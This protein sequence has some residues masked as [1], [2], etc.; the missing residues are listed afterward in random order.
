MTG[1]AIVSGPH[2]HSRLTVTN[3]MAMVMIC[4]LPATVMG[5]WQFGWPAIL[6]F[7][8]TV[9]SCLGFEAACLA[10]ARK[11]VERFLFD[12]SA[13]LTGW[14]LAM[15]LPP[16]APWWVGVA[17]AFIA[18]VIAKQ[19][20]GGLGQNLFNPAMVA[21]A[22][23]LIALP[24]QMTTWV[25]PEPVGAPGAPS[26]H[27]AL[28][29]T[30]GEGQAHI[31][32]FTGASTLGFVSAGLN[33]GATLDT[34]L[35]QTFTL[36]ELALGKVAG[37]MGETS[38]ALILLGGLLLIGARVIT[39][40]IPVSVLGAAAALSGA[41]WLHDPAHHASPAWHLTSGALMLTAFFIATDYVTSP[42][43]RTGQLIYG[44]GI[45]FLIVIIR[46]WGSFPEGA[47]FA[48]LLMN[49]CVPLLDTYIRP[50]IFGRDRRGKPLPLKGDKA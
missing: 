47:A 5:F 26:F 17:G 34:I 14:L 30:F 3:T 10:I 41:L 22:M 23:L 39:W 1:P 16:W 42:L 43:T 48:V 13:A 33:G 29:I 20:F 25:L 45:G 28:A 8:V 49:A 40:H 9:G 18:I 27:E 50:R 7:L 38:A 31:D 24:V 12:G 6:L 32:A 46:V 36:T 19:V 11:P 15:T 37:S 44:A 21:R 35:P 4:L 2:A